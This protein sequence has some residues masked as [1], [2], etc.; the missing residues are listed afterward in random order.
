MTTSRVSVKLG[1]ELLDIFDSLEFPLSL[2]FQIE[3]ITDFTK[4][5]GSG[6]N[7]IFKIPATANNNKIFNLFGT[8]SSDTDS[9]KIYEDI[10]IFLDDIPISSGS[11]VMRSV[12]TKG[13]KYL[14]EA[15]EYEIFFL[16]DNSEWFIKLGDKTLNELTFK[17]HLYNP[18]NISGLYWEGIL[19]FADYGYTLIKWKNWINETSGYLV[20]EDTT[21]FLYIADIIKKAFLSIG[22]TLDSNFL[23]SAFAERLIIPIPLK[24]FGEDYKNKYIN[25]RASNTADQVLTPPQSQSFVI[26]RFNDD[27]TLPNFDNGNNFNS[28]TFT[29][30]VPNGGEYRVRVSLT[31]DSI[32]SGG[33][34]PH[35]FIIN[36]RKNGILPATSNAF[37]IINGDTILFDKIYTYASGDTL[38][39]FIDIFGSITDY[40]I[41]AGG[42]LEIS[43]YY[44]PFILGETFIDW[45]YLAPKH[46]LRDII[47]GVSDIFNLYIFADPASRVVRIE[48]RNTFFDG[49]KDYTKDIDRSRNG[50][51]SF[52][53]IP[54]NTDYKYK[55]DGNDD[56]VKEVN[57]NIDIKLYSVRYVSI[58][59]TSSGTKRVENSFF[60]PTI[61]IKDNSISGLDNTDISPQIP[62]IYPTNYEEDKTITETDYDFLPRILYHK[63]V[64][65]FPSGRTVPSAEGSISFLSKNPTTRDNWPKSF[66][67]NYDDNTGLDPSLS[68]AREVL[69]TGVEVS[70]LIENYFLNHLASLN[71]GV[72]VS[73]FIRYKITDILS[74]NFR[75]KVFIDGIDYILQ[76]IDNYTP[77]SGRSTKT[78]LLED[79]CASEEDLSAL[80]F[81]TIIGIIKNLA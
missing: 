34:P 47:S 15:K 44:L 71:N 20:Y 27:S 78:I 43:S 6:S 74:L 60:A 33:P 9:L 72:Q 5:K 32:L 11:A 49:R 69:Y 23:S 66:V 46:Y 45:F 67:I 56:T 36:I 28:G 22:Y 39:I 37:S 13:G 50:V 52:T 77:I 73:E 30:T 35:S 18:N 48:P 65:S 2:D 64:I 38:E 70:G 24:E 61:H 55:E 12:I 51:K 68:Y 16:L 17:N 4:I 81:S 42:T 79:I 10:E 59:P 31:I 80:E 19:S 57:N 7:K 75:D 14:R 26:V 21:P 1:G 63:G 76:K 53:Q 40:T 58:N 41:K 8:Y 54:L 3:D 25:M 62:L 29:Y